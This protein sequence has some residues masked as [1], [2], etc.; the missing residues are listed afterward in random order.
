MQRV[1]RS[2]GGMAFGG[3][4][5]QQQQQQQQ[6]AFGQGALGGFGQLSTM[7]NGNNNQLAAARR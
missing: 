1:N 4:Q 5:Q 3:G 6:S 2:G 7:N